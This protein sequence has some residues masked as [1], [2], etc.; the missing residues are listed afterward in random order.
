MNEK[1]PIK[2]ESKII[3]RSEGWRMGF[4]RAKRESGS[5]LGR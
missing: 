1:L 3:C 2:F 4:A 5:E